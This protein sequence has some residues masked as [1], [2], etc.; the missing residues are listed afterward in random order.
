MAR[1]VAL[2]SV[3]RRNSCCGVLQVMVAG[4]AVPLCCRRGTAQRYV[5]GFDSSLQSPGGHGPNSAEDENDGG[6]Q[7][8]R[9]KRTPK[10]S[11]PTGISGEYR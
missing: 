5:M 6:E 4:A 1:E 10:W 11:G 3:V 8:I 9:V 2:S 7:T